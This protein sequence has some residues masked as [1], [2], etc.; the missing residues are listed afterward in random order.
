MKKRHYQGFTLI[1][2]L[3]TIAILIIALGIGLPSFGKL[4]EDSHR[5]DTLHQLMTAISYARTEAITRSANITL[6]PL[7]T[8]GKCSTDWNKPITKFVDP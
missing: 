2:L 7:D 8:N 3:L 5:K 6:C 4:I 1:E